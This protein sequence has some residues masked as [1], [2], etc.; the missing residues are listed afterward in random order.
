LDNNEN[1]GVFAVFD[2]HVDKNA[3]VKAASLLPQ[4][5]SEKIRKTAL[6]NDSSTLLTESFL[7]TDLQ[8]KEF[9]TEGTTAT[10]VLV[11]RVN[12]I[13]Y[14]QAANVGDSSAFLK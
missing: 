10:T 9:D 14:L 1:V 6:S 13:S 3:A 7:D 4:V 8:L 5:L 11:W 12:G 2:G